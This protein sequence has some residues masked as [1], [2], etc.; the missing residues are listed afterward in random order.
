[1][2][3]TRQRNNSVCAT[4]LRRATIKSYSAGPFQCLQN[5]C[6]TTELRRPALRESTRSPLNSRGTQREGR[7]IGGGRALCPRA[8]VT[9]RGGL[10]G[11]RSPPARAGRRGPSA[12]AVTTFH[13]W[14]GLVPAG[15]LG[16]DV[17]IAVA[18]LVIHRPLVSTIGHVSMWTDTRADALLV[19]RG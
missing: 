15:W 11:L 17:F 5:S 2:R 4:H 19:G 14:Q 9:R 6:S 13:A 8:A 10:R 12:L 3:M 18:G 16:V 7:R 1:M